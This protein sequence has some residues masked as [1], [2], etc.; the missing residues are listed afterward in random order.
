[1]NLIIKLLSYDLSHPLYIVFQL[2]I[3]ET[4]EQL[5]ENQLIIFNL[6]NVILH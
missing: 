2:I 6:K 5:Y 3:H 4:H 1:M